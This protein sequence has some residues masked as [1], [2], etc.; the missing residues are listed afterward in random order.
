[1]SHPFND[2]TTEKGLV[3]LYERELSFD[4]G[5][6]SGSTTRL[7]QFA[8]DVNTVFDDYVTLAI[9]SSGTWQFDDSNQTDF[10]IITTNLVSGQRAYL[11]TTD[12]QSNVILDI[13]RVL[14]A[15]DSGRYHEISP[16]DA[17]QDKDTHGFWDGTDTTGTPLRYDKTANAIFLDPIPNYNETN[18]LKVY[19]NREPSYFVYSDTTKNPGVPGLHHKYFYVRP[20][21]DYARRKSLAIYPTLRAER[22]A[23]EEAIT[24]YFSERPRDEH[25][26][27][28]A[29]QQSN[30]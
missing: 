11:F 1:M 23:L 17:Q 10:P 9:K 13:H 3:Q 19:I 7:K 2:T 25:R 29:M 14:V 22:L 4:S 6:V 8:A 15:D 30:R 16:V 26:R 5:T 18:G 28:S 24:T 27:L 12:E 21:E 20:A